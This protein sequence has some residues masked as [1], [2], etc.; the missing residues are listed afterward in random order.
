MESNNN[1]NDLDLKKLEVRI[2]ELIRT[3]A[4]LKQENTTLR[5]SQTDLVNERA[6][7]VEKTEL[8][9]ARVE[10]MITRLKTLETG[11]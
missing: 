3:C 8:A 9:R 7:L 11:S 2:E 6:E 10:S 4:R 5:S 1:N